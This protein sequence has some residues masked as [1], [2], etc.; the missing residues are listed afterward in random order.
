MKNLRSMY[1]VLLRQHRMQCLASTLYQSSPYDVNVAG[2][3]R[4]QQTQR[5]EHVVLWANSIIQKANKDILEAFVRMVRIVSFIHPT[6]SCILAQ[7]AFSTS[8]M[9]L[10]VKK[11][12]FSPLS[13]LSPNRTW[14]WAYIILTHLL[15]H[16]HARSR[17]D[18][19]RC[20]EESR[21]LKTCFLHQAHLGSILFIPVFV[22]LYF[23]RL[24]T[25]P[26]SF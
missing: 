12:V 1:V 14:G 15:L 23:S 11:I 5:K 16:F 10:F 17:I 13:F 26:R 7:N 24:W 22:P 8:Q 2:D 9:M 18:S 3:K 25:L 20:L 21:C 19:V 4:I 6:W